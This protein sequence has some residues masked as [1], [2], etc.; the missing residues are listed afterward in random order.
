MDKCHFASSILS[1][2]LR[3]FLLCAF[4]M[5]KASDTNKVKQVQQ[6]ENKMSPNTNY[7]MKQ[8]NRTNGT[9]VPRQK[10]SIREMLSSRRIKVH[11]RAPR[12]Q[13][14]VQVER[15]PSSITVKMTRQLIFYA[16]LRR[17]QRLRRRRRR[18]RCVKNVCFLRSYSF[19]FA[20]DRL[21]GKCSALDFHIFACL[22]CSVKFVPSSFFARTGVCMLQCTVC[23]ERGMRL[24]SCWN[25]MFI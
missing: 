17:Q 1:L 23:A 8:T 2:T 11:N 24:F 13:M 10:M 9:H 18:G 15:L 25:F 21:L 19:S 5:K 12:W 4:E 22:D 16:V 7:M 6:Q 20:S 3:L 14:H